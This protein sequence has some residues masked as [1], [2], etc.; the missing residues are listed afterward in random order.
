MTRLT[1]NPR[2]ESRIQNGVKR[3]HNPTITAASNMKIIGL[4]GLVLLCPLATASFAK[5]ETAKIA[6]VK[7]KVNDCVLPL[8]WKKRKIEND[9]IHTTGKTTK[10][11]P[12][13][14]EFY[15]DNDQLVTV[16]VL[17]T[18]VNKARKIALELMKTPTGQKCLE[19]IFDD[20]KFMTTNLVAAGELTED[21]IM[22]V[23][24]ASG[25][26]SI[27]A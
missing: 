12:V 8:G 18:S 17:N 7:V 4:I 22:M 1:Q 3:R 10:V 11:R 15:R 16:N 25:N 26:L 9:Y 2:S 23:A 5:G 19:L 13:K 27:R 6:G 20:D 21:A 14:P 24:F